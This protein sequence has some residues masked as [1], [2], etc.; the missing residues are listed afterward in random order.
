MAGLVGC[1]GGCAPEAPREPAATEADQPD[2][3]AV[4][5]RVRA[6]HAETQTID[7][8]QA[9]IAAFQMQMGRLP[10]SLDELVA[11]NYLDALPEAP[12]GGRF[13]YD[14]VRGQIDLKSTAAPDGD[15]RGTESSGLILPPP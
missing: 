1:L 4:L 5:Q 11:R 7:D 8:L 6:Q 10:R 2:Y 12:D 14:P 15:D 9:R 13:A 3:R